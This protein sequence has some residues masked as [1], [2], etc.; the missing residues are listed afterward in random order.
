MI[1]ISRQYKTNIGYFRQQASRKAASK[2]A[3]LYPN[4]NIKLTNSEI[5]MDKSLQRPVKIKIKASS[6]NPQ[7]Q[8]LG[9]DKAVLTQKIYRAD[10][11]NYYDITLESAIGKIFTHFNTQEKAIATTE[12][13]HKSQ[14]LT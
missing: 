7:L 13:K 3:A 6:Q 12:T 4:T 2:F 5:I 1:N 14:I 8:S 11:R 10:G 9:K